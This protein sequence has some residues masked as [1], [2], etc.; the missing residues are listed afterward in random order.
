ML[1]VTLALLLGL[2]VGTAVSTWA[3]AKKFQALYIAA[4]QVAIQQQ[5]EIDRKN[6]MYQPR[7]DA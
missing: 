1:D 7:G 6:G 2:A 5:N 4:L 3:W